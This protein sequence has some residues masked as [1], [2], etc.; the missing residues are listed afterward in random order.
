MEACRD[1]ILGLLLSLL[2]VTLLNSP[3][4]RSGPFEKKP[5]M[6]DLVIFVAVLAGRAVC[7][8]VRLSCHGK[9]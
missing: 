5:K 8:E 3:S 1:T 9:H 7:E 4:R 2:V 6:G